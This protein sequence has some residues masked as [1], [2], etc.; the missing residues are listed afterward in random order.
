MGCGRT[1]NLRGVFDARERYRQLDMVTCNGSPTVIA[2]TL[3]RKNYRAVPTMSDGRAGAPL[4]L[5]G[6]FQTFLLETSGTA[7]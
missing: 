5:R 1:P 7:K 6:L 2:W 4:E 3:D